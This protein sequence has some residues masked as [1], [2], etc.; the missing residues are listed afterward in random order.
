MARKYSR[1]NFQQMKKAIDNEFIR[2]FLDIKVKHVCDEVGANYNNI[3]NG[4]ANPEATRMVRNELERRMR[5]IMG[6]TTER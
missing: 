4:V 6:L 3:K 1:R 5:K 2:G